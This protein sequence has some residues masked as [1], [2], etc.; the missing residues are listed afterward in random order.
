M[1]WYG[2]LIQISALALLVGLCIPGAALAQGV[3][4]G[5]KGGIVYPQ[6]THDIE[7]LELDNRAGWQAGIFFGGNREGVVGIQGELNWLRKRTTVDFFGDDLDVDVDY[8]QIP[9]LLRLHS[10][11]QSA[12]SFQFYGIVGPTFDIKLRE[13]FAD[14]LTIDE[15]FE[16]VDIG[17]MFGAGV[18]AGR[19][20]FEGRYSRGLRNV[21]KSF[22]DVSEI[23][24]HSF[25]LLL[26][27]RLN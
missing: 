8:L 5:L 27:V 21:N 26:G 17:I 16:G 1:T 13:Q 9:V 15:G 18:E 24:T 14:A 3:G 7:D 25:A 4:V 23:K 11:A 20:L 19:I 6:F 2:R 22:D 12:Q 10:P